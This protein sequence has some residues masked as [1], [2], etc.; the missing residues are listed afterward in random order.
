MVKRYDEIEPSY[1]CDYIP[2][3][4]CSPGNYFLEW[5]ERIKEAFKAF[6]Y[7]IKGGDLSDYND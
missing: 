2:S 7:V 3:P 4:S 1:S 6:V 5:R